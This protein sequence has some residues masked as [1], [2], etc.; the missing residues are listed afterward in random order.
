MPIEDSHDTQHHTP[1][2]GTS[3]NLWQR[4][5]SRSRWSSSVPVSPRCSRN[6]TIFILR[7][8]SLSMTTAP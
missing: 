5:I 1:R 6:T 8:L 4:S 2:E 7:T 3:R